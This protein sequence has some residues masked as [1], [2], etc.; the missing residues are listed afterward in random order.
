MNKI[1]GIRK[2]ELIAEYKQ[3][4]T[5]GGVFRIW[6]KESGKSLIK[7]DVNLQAVENRLRFSQKV[8]S[9]YTIALQQDWA[10]YGGNSF[11]LEIL[12]EAK[13][14]AEESLG[15]FKDRLKRMEEAWKEKYPPQS[16][17]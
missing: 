2:K 17:Y 1:D 5:T 9:P 12:E 4:D 14:S 7:G 10:R 15:A 8:D 6:N 16:I 3:Q 11:S 13:Q